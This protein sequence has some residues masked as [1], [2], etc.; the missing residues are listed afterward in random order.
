[1]GQ[2]QAEYGVMRALRSFTKRRVIT[3][4]I[5]VGSFA[6]HI[7]AFA[8]YAA[9][10]RSAYVCCV[11][12]HMVVECH[13]DADFARVVNSADFATADGMP[14][15]HSL[16]LFHR[17]KQERVAGNDIMPAVMT[18][19]AKRGLKVYLYGGTTDMEQ[20]IKTRASTE[21]PDLQL[22]GMY[23]PPFGP[24]EALDMNA[25]AARINTAGAHIILVS[26]GC[27]KQE[28]WMAAMKGR[29]D[30][31]MI[32]LGGAFLVYASIDTRAPKWMR[33]L[34]LEWL[35]RLRL[36][37]SRLWKRYLITNSVFIALFLKELIILAAK[38]TWR[39]TR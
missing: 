10:H 7:S 21:L 37:P 6:E 16:Q 19:A 22:A 29:V 8:E 1:M 30:G 3:A 35:H 15:L 25:E 31:I 27:P 5:S 11:N 18:L 28:R 32:G 13:K 33:N 39:R 2:M 24:L 36:E 14:V 34:C 9:L 38:R 12:A 26:L 20:R 4:D 23:A 17:V